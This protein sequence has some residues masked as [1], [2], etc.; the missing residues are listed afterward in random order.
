M[1]QPNLTPSSF[2]SAPTYG[3]QWLVDLSW[4]FWVFAIV[5]ALAGLYFL[6][7]FL[8]R[9]PDR[10]KRRCPKCWYEMTGVTGLRCPE[11]GREHASE[12]KLFKRRR[13][14]F[15]ALAAFLLLLF[16]I[17][18]ALTPR[19]AQHGWID[20]TPTLALIAAS[21]IY[22]TDQQ[23]LYRE[24]GIRILK[25]RRSGN[26]NPPSSSG[27]PP[28]VSRLSK[29]W[30]IRRAKSQLMTHQGPQPLVRP[31]SGIPGWFGLDM[32]AFTISVLCEMYT[33]GF[34]VVPTIVQ[35][36]HHT[37][38]PTQYAV[39]QEV[40]TNSHAPRQ[41][42]REAVRDC[43]RTNDPD[44][45]ELAADWL[46]QTYPNPDDI[47]A[48]VDGT[49]RHP[50][51]LRLLTRYSAAGADACAD[52][53]NDPDLAFGAARV[54]RAIDRSELNLPKVLQAA[55]LSTNP[56]V[57]AECVTIFAIWSKPDPVARL[58]LA[59]ILTTDPSENVRLYALSN[60]SSFCNSKIA[61]Y[62]P[63]PQV[64]PSLIRDLSAE[65]PSMRLLCALNLA[66]FGPDAASALPALQAIV[67]NPNE[68]NSLR[69]AAADA[70]AAINT[71]LPNPPIAPS[72]LPPAAL[73]AH[74]PPDP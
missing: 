60:L 51:H 13:K 36:I 57:R 39:L 34:D 8:L 21:Y 29:S 16:A 15:Q 47:P 46:A 12:R 2:F 55:K 24:A 19:V 45:F 31:A 53:L 50:G 42:I 3:P 64:V 17:S 10:H 11:C 27:G 33:D 26:G 25:E 18:A 28:S 58:F 38:P 68:P 73:P 32:H 71:S 59:D 72:S 7:R 6:W 44:V 22:D 14:R 20:S 52:L 5:F 4:L 37:D 35:A 54:L 63:A 49:R 65:S 62:L 66:S 23:L 61:S 69:K 30:F 67:D 74:S 1:S 70:I 40:T 43:L 56:A 48:L 9:D 41:A